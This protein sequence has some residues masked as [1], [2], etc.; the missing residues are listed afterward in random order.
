MHLHR[1]STTA[2]LGSTDYVAIN[3]ASVLAVILGLAS[4][5]AVVDKILLIVPLAGL[6]CGVVA[7]YQIGRSGGTQTG[8]GLAV[9]GLLLS[10]GFAAYVGYQSFSKLRQESRDRASIET[11]VSQFTGNVQNGEF[12]QAYNLFSPRF[13]ERVKLQEFSDRMKFVQDGSWGKL[14]SISTSG[15]YAFNSDP[16]SGV[17]ISQTILQMKLD[18]FPEASNQEAVFRLV[19]GHWKIEDI[20]GL[21]PAANQ[22]Q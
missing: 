14:Q 6:I 3:A 8:R 1:M 5:L 10:L 15:R 12:D 4:A 9:L 16:A 11:V 20:P 17:R 19:G 7:L 2:G 22:Q 18:K 13:Q 21:F